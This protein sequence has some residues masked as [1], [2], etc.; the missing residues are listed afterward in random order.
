MDKLCTRTESLYLL[1]QSIF[2]NHFEK[3]YIR[4][5]PN[6]AVFQEMLLK[7][8][9]F[10]ERL[11]QKQL[12]DNISF[13]Y[14]HGSP[15]E[16]SKA[17]RKVDESWT[18]FF[19][20]DNKVYCGFIGEKIASFCLLDDMG[21]HHIDGHSFRIGAPGCVGTLP[22]FRSMGIGLTMIKNAT[23]LLKNEGFDYSYIHF[24]NVAQWYAKLGYK[25]FAEWNKNGII[26]LSSVV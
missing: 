16:L 6:D 21:T 11:Y 18:E 22:E 23:L 20:A 8:D 12:N 17:V 5:L 2:P 15:D 7:L 19:T 14:Y 10:D 1:F 25:A 24:T 3:D 4:S 26:R 9:N 13:G